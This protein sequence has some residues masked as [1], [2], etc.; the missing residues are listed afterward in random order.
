MST[1]Y[2]SHLVNGSYLE[3]DSL[4]TDGGHTNAFLI[5]EYHIKGNEKTLGTAVMMLL[6]VCHAREILLKKY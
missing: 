3:E 5:D 2:R 6:I 4:L 1:M